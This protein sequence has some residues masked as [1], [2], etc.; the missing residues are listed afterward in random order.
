MN[1]SI[2]RINPLV[3]LAGTACVMLYE[4][5][6]F[7]FFPAILKDARALAVLAVAALAIGTDIFIRPSTEK[8][9]KDRY[10]SWK[11]NLFFL[12]S[13]LLLFAPYLENIYLSRLYQSGLA[14]GIEYGIGLT[15]S[16][17]GGVLLISSRII[18]GQYG[19]PKLAIQEGYALVTTGPY[20]YVRNPLYSADL[21]LYGG[22]ALAFGSWISFVLSILLL[23]AIVV[24]RILIEEQMLE[25]T[26]KEEY[27]QWK[28]KT[29]RLLPFIW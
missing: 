13:P 4:L 9:V 28:V 20:R 10:K 16:L 22:Y 29:W 8:N 6:P 23:L 2:R 1:T 17:L 25:E 24:E 26:F 15:L 3:K 12:A 7:F 19:T 5:F 27:A 21:L 14:L 11:I 18:I